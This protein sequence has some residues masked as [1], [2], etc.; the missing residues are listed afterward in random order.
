MQLETWSDEHITI[1]ASM[2]AAAMRKVEPAVDEHAAGEAVSRDP[3][4]GASA[5]VYCQLCGHK[6][7]RSENHID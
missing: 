5:M 3:R 7:N 2:D 1:Q 4:K 6:H